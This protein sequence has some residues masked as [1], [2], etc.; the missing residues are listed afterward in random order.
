M[1]KLLL[2]SLLAI[3]LFALLIS[4]C[5]PAATPTAAP[6]ANSNVRQPMNRL[7]LRPWLTPKSRKRTYSRA[8][9]D[10][11]P[12]DRYRTLGWRPCD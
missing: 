8:R 12:C 4:A 5:A 9:A 2:K 6:A 7:R 1:N 10:R 3:M 11:N